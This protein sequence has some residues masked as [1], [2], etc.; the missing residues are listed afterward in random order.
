[1]TTDGYSAYLEAVAAAFGDDVDYAMLSKVASR[2]ELEIR[3]EIVSGDPDEDHI[4]T[5]LIE[6]QNLTLRMSSRRYTR[7]TNAFSK[8]MENHALAIALHFLH[9]N[10][11][12]IHSTLR[13]TPAMATGVTDRLYGLDWILDMVDEAWPKPDR[14]KTYKRSRYYAKR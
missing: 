2:E 8:K 14:P 5:T 7:K 11:I 6:R 12:R 1:M 10:F 13:I 3:K 4:S 9:Y